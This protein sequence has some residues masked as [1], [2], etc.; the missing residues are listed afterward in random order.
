MHQHI[1]CTYTNLKCVECN[2]IQF[3]FQ[4]EVF[5]VIWKVILQLSLKSLSASVFY[6][7]WPASLSPLKR[8][9]PTACCH[10]HRVSQWDGVIRMMQ[11]VLQCRSNLTRENFSTLFAVPPTWLE[12]NFK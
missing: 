3:H 1:F 10:H 2:Y 9:I 6:Q 12:A 8:R 5:W 4:L 7:L 11:G